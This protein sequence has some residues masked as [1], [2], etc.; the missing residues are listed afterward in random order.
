MS[1]FF[2]KLGMLLVLLVSIYSPQNCFSEN[3]SLV[4]EQLKN[5]QIKSFR[6]EDKKI[7][8]KS[9]ISILQE[10]GFM[11]DKMYSDLG[12]I[13]AFKEL[14][15]EQLS[16]VFIGISCWGN[17]ASWEKQKIIMATIDLREQDEQL[18]VRV[19]FRF[20]ILNNHGQL[21]TIEQVTNPRFYQEFYD[22][23]DEEVSSFSE[24]F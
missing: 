12:M 11:I 9:I 10:D 20:K 18:R 13:T 3:A 6:A 16:S 21:V 19:N 4:Q 5:V 23:L 8:F 22:K 2:R 17:K 14:D 24:L 15:I 7:V 1:C